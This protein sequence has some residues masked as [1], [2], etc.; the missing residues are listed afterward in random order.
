MVVRMHNAPLAVA[1]RGV[2]LR[3]LPWRD[4]Q[5]SSGHLLNMVDNPTVVEGLRHQLLM[6]GGLVFKRK[7]SF[8]TSDGFYR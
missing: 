5:V 8:H 1:P 4:Y 3:V 7:C 2:P 6:L